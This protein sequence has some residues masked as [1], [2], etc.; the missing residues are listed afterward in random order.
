MYLTPQEFLQ[1]FPSSSLAELLGTPTIKDGNGRVIGYEPIIPEDLEPF[2]DA[3][4]SEVE[5][6]LAGRY[7]MPLSTVPASLK[8]VIADIARYRIYADKVTELI[9]I[10]YEQAV[11]F[12]K[13]VSAGKASLGPGVRTASGGGSAVV[14]GSNSSANGQYAFS[15]PVRKMRNLDDF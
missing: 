2:I 11:N 15:A 1:M 7:E 8:Q 13:S 3:A 4:E 5:A 9:Q 6:Y 12:L 14:S 10:R